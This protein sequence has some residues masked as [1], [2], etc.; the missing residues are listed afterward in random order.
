MILNKTARKT[1]AQRNPQILVRITHVLDPECS[2]LHLD[3]QKRPPTYHVSPVYQKPV[4]GNNRGLAFRK[5]SEQVQVYWERVTT[6]SSRIGTTIVFSG[7]PVR[8]RGHLPSP[9]RARV[10]GGSAVQLN[11]PIAVR[12]DERGDLVICDVYNSRVQLCSAGSFGSACNTVAGVDGYG[13]GLTQLAVPNGLDLDAAGDYVIA[14]WNNHRVLLCP[15]SDPSSACNVVA[16]GSG[17]GLQQLQT[18]APVTVGATGDY[19]A[20]DSGN[21]RV[22]ACSAASPGSDCTV[23]VVAADGTDLSWP[24][25]VAI[26]SNGD[27]VVTD[28]NNHR[29]LLCPAEVGTECTIVTGGLGVGSGSAQ[30]SG[31]SG[32]DINA[33]GDY[34]IADRGITESNCRFGIMKIPRIVQRIHSVVQLLSLSCEFILPQFLSRKCV[35]LQLLR[36]LQFFHFL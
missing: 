24:H 5:D 26:D 29:I 3:F 13:S 12:L 22:V 30:L 7:V 28:L 21:H 17:S 2:H 27:L 10:S 14:E 16:G 31:P 20:S 34:V 9:W 19:I 23:L 1:V 15:A 6:T 33:N 36:S 18:P 35:C 4:A 11:Q 32:V 25:E 8:N